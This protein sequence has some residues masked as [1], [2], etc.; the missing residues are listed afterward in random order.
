MKLQTI[1]NER[2]IK[3]ENAWAPFPKAIYKEIN[4]KEC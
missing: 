2:Q 3:Q 4:K 1:K